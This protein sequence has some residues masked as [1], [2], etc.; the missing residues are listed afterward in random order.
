[1]NKGIGYSPREFRTTTNEKIGFLPEAE[2]ENE[3]I[4]PLLA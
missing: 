3:I 4:F 1:V 2:I